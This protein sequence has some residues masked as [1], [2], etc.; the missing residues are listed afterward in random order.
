MVNLEY[1]IFDIIEIKMDFCL[2]IIINGLL[3][4][5]PVPV[6]ILR[7]SD[8]GPIMRVFRALSKSGVARGIRSAKPQNIYRS[9]I[10][11]E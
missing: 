6:A 2:S 3:S 8:D 1:L 5:P 10:A 7:C 4:I 9:S 11:N